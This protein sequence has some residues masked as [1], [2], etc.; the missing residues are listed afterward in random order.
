MKSPHR[1]FGC[2]AGDAATFTAIRLPEPAPL[3]EGE[4]CRQVRE[5]LTSG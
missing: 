3:Q 1:L 5:I 2:D 4:A